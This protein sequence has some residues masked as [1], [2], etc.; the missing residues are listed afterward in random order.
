VSVWEEEIFCVVVTVTNRVPHNGEIP[1]V[2]GNELCLLASFGTSPPPPGPGV[3][4]YVDCVVVVVPLGR[5]QA[6]GGRGTAGTAHWCQCRLPRRFSPC[7]LVPR[8]L[9]RCETVCV[10]VVHRLR[11]RAGSWAARNPPNEGC[12]SPI[13]SGFLARNPI[14]G[15]GCLDS[16]RL[17]WLLCSEAAQAGL[18]RLWRPSGNIKHSLIHN[19]RC[20]SGLVRAAPWLR[21]LNLMNHIVNEF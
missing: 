3:R 11:A 16:A 14:P 2:L 21:S 9:P 15:P 17:E 8:P 1:V 18:S 6:A 20:S 10:A 12:W 5:R 7:L 19:C 4:L 13:S